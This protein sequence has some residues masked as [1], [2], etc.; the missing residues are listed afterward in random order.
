MYKEYHMKKLISSVL[1]ASLIFVLSGCVDIKGDTTT[2]TT[3]SY[4]TTTTYTEAEKDLLLQSY[5]PD[6]EGVCDTGYAWCSIEKLCL[7]EI[8]GA[9]CGI[10]EDG[11]EAEAQELEDNNTT[12]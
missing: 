2:N 11:E 4:N 7:P 5:K 1:G 10:H 6:V 3:D 12:V 8:G 9:I